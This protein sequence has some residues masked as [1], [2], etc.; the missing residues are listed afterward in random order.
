MAEAT[1]KDWLQIRR[2]HRLPQV[3]PKHAEIETDAGAVAGGA[4]QRLQVVAGLVKLTH[5]LP[6][7][8]ADVAD[9]GGGARNIKPV[10]APAA[11]CSTERENEGLFGAY[12]RG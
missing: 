6:R 10:A 4:E 9:D 1:G 3:D 7:V 12:I 2:I 8:L 5:Q 11:A